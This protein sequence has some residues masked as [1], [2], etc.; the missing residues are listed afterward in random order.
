VSFFFCVLDFHNGCIID[1]FCKNIPGRLSFNLSEEVEGGNDDIVTDDD[2]N[3][4]K[5]E[6]AQR[7]KIKASSNSEFIYIQN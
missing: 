3:L 6:R 5:F 4:A 7:S 2:N 1:Q